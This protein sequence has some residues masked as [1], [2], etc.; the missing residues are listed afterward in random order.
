MSVISCPSPDWRRGHAA[1][2]PDVRV[3]RTACRV[4]RT[5]S[6]CGSVCFWSAQPSFFFLHCQFDLSKKALAVR[7][8]NLEFAVDEHEA[9]LQARADPT[10]HVRNRPQLILGAQPAAQSLVVRIEDVVL[11][12][13]VA[14]VEL[15]LPLHL[16]G[17]ISRHDLE[18]DLD[19][20]AVLY[21]LAVRAAISL[22]PP[23]HHVNVWRHSDFR[24]A[25]DGIPKIVAGD[26]DRRIVL[27]EDFK[28]AL[29]RHHPIPLE[30][31]VGHA[32]S[33]AIRVYDGTTSGA[34]IEG[35][36]HARPRGRWGDTSSR[37]T[38]PARR[39]RARLPAAC[40]AA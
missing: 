31:I 12:D 14:L 35:T 25:F 2:P 13:A 23:E 11:L 15:K 27:E 5:A 16:A 18:D 24:F 30:R 1:A 29:D 28:S 39:V 21:P 37:I 6:R 36:R 9:D 26:E 32:F 19:C 34:L 17:T 38:S 3:A 8:Q 22:R 7:P 20:N 4:A 10:G 40:T 33:V